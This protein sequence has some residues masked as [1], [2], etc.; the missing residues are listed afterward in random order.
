MAK[1]NKD[2]ILREIRGNKP[3]KEIEKIR[4]TP[5]QPDKLMEAVRATWEDMR[6][7]RERRHDYIAEYVGDQYG[8]GG[9]KYWRNDV[10]A[11]VVINKINQ[12]VSTYMHLLASGTPRV[13]VS[14]KYDDLQE[15]AMIMEAALNQRIEEVNVTDALHRAVLEAMF[16]MGVVKTG[17]A[18]GAEEYEVEGVLYD[19]GQPRTYA[20]DFDN[21]VI[22][23]QA[24]SLDEIEFIGDR[25]LR[26]K[27]WIEER[28]N[29][30]KEAGEK[31][32][33]LRPE[34]RVSGVVEDPKNR[35]VE[36]Q[37][38]WNIYLPKHNWTCLRIVEGEDIPFD[39]T[40]WSGPETGPYD[41]ITFADVPGEVMGLPPVM[42]LY[43]MHNHENNLVRKLMNQAERQ[44]THAVVQ[45]G[46]D[47]DLETIRDADDGAAIALENPGSVAELSW[48]GANMSNHNMAMW[49]NDMFDKSGGNLELLGGLSAQSETLGQD[50]LL[51]NAANVRVSAMAQRVRRFMKK[52]LKKHAWFIWFEEFATIDV[53]LPVIDNINVIHNLTPEEREGDWV[54]YNFD[55]DPYSLQDETPNEKLQKLMNIW[56]NFVLPS[57][58]ISMQAG[59]MP[60]FEDVGRKVAKYSNMEFEDMF[61]QVDPNSPFVAQPQ[62]GQVPVPPRFKQSHTVNERVN[63]SGTTP[64]SERNAYLESNAQMMQSQD[65]SG[66]MQAMG[67]VA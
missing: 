40:E 41:I 60:N 46:D 47:A 3:K 58:D 62:H 13:L 10:R 52:V 2:S 9:Q 25:C 34:D 57:Q 61:K 35:L 11:K 63:K 67:G 29:G 19:P 59:W 43:H 1:V 14:T 45:R 16:S 15:F 20:I 22:D 23:M 8:V 39:E 56:Q 42:P 26:P 53:K 37:W 65:N 33:T 12:F 44:K 18:A 4:Y 27:A 38:I 32:D 50:Q 17:L 64:G 28:K 6:D 7:F 21:F 54:D 31:R 30:N 55:I 66:G 24:S 5:E 49:L 51:A 48:G 36:K